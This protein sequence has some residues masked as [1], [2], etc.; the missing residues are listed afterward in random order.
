MRRISGSVSAGCQAAPRPRRTLVAEIGRWGVCKSSGCIARWIR[1]RWSCCRP[2]SLDF[3]E[4][5]KTKPT[6]NPFVAATAE[7]IKKSLKVADISKYKVEKGEPYLYFY[8]CSEGFFMHAKSILE[9]M[10]P[11]VSENLKSWGLKVEKPE[12]PF[13][14]IIMPSREAFDAYH[15]MPK[16]V[17]AYYENMSNYIVMYEDQDLVDSSPRVRGQTGRLYRRSRR[18]ASIDVQRRHQAAAVELAALDHRRNGGILLPAEGQFEPRQKKQIGT[19]GADDEMVQ[20]GHGQRPAT[21]T[22]S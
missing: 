19:S 2:A 16:E 9:T 3:V 11:G 10:L 17:A 1:T 18:R 20:G 13:V 4:R 12:M 6:T 7:E 15:P 5:E 8:N 21:C 14:V 22:G